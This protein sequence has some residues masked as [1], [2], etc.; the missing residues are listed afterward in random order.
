MPAFEHLQLSLDYYRIRIADAIGTSG[1]QYVL[2]N[3][4]NVTGANPT[5]SASNPSCQ[6]IDRNFG[7]VPGGSFR[8]GQPSQNLGGLLNSGIDLELDWSW[9]LADLGLGRNAGQVSFNSTMSWT[10]EYKI[11]QVPGAPW[12][13]YTGSVPINLSA[14]PA[15]PQWHSLSQLSY[16]VA[17]IPVT[18]GLRWR[19]IDAMRDISTVLNPASAV[20][21]VRRFNYLDVV[22]SWNITDRI[23]VS[24]TVTNVSGQTP[25]VV[26]GTPGE[27][28]PA[29]YDIAPRT[30][31]VTVHAKF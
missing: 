26:S 18:V 27:T 8:I 31:L 22:A 12:L 17:P 5:Y 4:Y 25:P 15:V 28:Q 14:T 1:Y 7:G 30:Y 6:L 19:Y 21:G 29:L 16:T 20:P 3:C 13:D 2:N 9:H 23:D 24:G 10:D 11:Q